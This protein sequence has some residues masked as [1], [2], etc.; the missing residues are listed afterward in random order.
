VYGF[1]LS[2]GA[3]TWLRYIQERDEYAARIAALA[4]MSVTEKYPNRYVNGLSNNEDTE[5][6]R[7]RV[8]SVPQWYIHGT[9][10][11]APHRIGPVRAFVAA[12]K[13]RGADITLTERSRL[14]HN[15]GWNICTSPTWS[16]PINHTQYGWCNLHIKK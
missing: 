2:A 10:D 7:K 15:C 1:G 6:L 3:E 14:G 8:D 11:E 5:A 9:I 16:S 13:A 12:A 4:L